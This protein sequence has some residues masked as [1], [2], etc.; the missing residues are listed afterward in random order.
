MPRLI[1]FSCWLVEYTRR[2]ATF[3]M[4]CGVPNLYM[5]AKY[6]LCNCSLLHRYYYFI[7]IEQDF[8]KTSIS[9]C[10]MKVFCTTDLITLSLLE[11][12]YFDLVSALS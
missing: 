11:E 1:Q 10:R 6:L 2:R 5:W 9:A 8:D 12:L 3:C 7:L 4:E